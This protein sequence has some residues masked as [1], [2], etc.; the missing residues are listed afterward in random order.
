[1]FRQLE[2]LHFQT[3]LMITVKAN[4]VNIFSISA[5]HESPG[6][7]AA[8]CCCHSNVFRTK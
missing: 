8:G 6:D 4:N 5:D 3:L 7:F 2:S 1:M